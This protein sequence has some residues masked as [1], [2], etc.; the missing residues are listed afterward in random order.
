MRLEVG[1]IAVEGLEFGGQT[2]LDGRTLLVDRD[3][4]R[5]LVLEAPHFAAVA[6]PPARP[7]ES[8]RIAHALDVPEP[9]WKTDGPGGVFPGFVTDPVS[10]GDGHTRR[11]AGAAAGE[12]GG[13]APGEG[14]H[15]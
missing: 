8:I 7:G 5:R 9:R 6:V 3:E 14:T 1:S 2:A 13:P 11:L 12:V 4:I 10:A 15:I